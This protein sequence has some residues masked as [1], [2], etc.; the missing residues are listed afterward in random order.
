MTNAISAGPW[1]A[2]GWLSFTQDGW[3]GTLHAHSRL[4]WIRTVPVPPA[5]PIDDVLTSRVTP[6]RPEGGDGVRSVVDDDPHAAA[7][8][9]RIAVESEQEIQPLPCH[10]SAAQRTQTACHAK[11]RLHDRECASHDAIV[12][13]GSNSCSELFQMKK[14]GGLTRRGPARP[15]ARDPARVFIRGTCCRALVQAWKQNAG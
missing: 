12:N 3:V 4:V 10:R 5:E 7:I 15:A 2:V 11:S 14:R 1:V 9:P 13:T 8:E 6:Q